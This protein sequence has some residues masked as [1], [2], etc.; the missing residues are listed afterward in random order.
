MN[1]EGAQVLRGMICPCTF[2][3]SNRFYLPSYTRMLFEITRR[4]AGSLSPLG[5]YVIGLSVCTGSGF[6]L[7][8]QTGKGFL[9]MRKLSLYT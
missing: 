1:D 9:L 8:D 2:S 3:Q 4:I 5:L 7:G 6:P